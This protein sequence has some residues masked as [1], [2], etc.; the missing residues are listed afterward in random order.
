MEIKSN[1][2]LCI[3]KFGQAYDLSEYVWG[4][5]GDRCKAEGNSIL[6]KN[7]TWLIDNNVNFYIKYT[8]SREYNMW[9]DEDGDMLLF[10]YN[11]VIPDDK[12]AMYFKLSRG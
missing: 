8:F 7:L 6:N 12:D 10:L 2:S 11:I 4:K 9:Q 5:I 1:T 3:K